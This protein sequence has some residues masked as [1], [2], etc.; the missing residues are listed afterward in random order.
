[1]KKEREM[2]LHEYYAKTWASYPGADFNFRD[3]EDIYLTIQCEL[4]GILNKYNFNEVFIGVSGGID[5]I[6]LACLLEKMEIRARYIFVKHQFYREKDFKIAHKVISNHLNRPL[7]V[8]EKFPYI[9]CQKSNILNELVLNYKYIE[10]ARILRKERIAFLDTTNKSEAILNLDNFVHCQAHYYPFWYVYKTEICALAKFLKVPT[11][12]IQPSHAGLKHW[13]D[14]E[15]FHQ[16]SFKEADACH[17]H[18]L[19]KADYS[20]CATE[21]IGVFVNDRLNR[22]FIEDFKKFEE[23]PNE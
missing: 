10:F 16:F 11:D 14:D 1:M 20:A 8:I 7:T 23:R 22:L 12:C 3:P 17:R 19:K 15:K 13:E 18:Y 21:G 5:S 2:F 9:E 4:R 6:V